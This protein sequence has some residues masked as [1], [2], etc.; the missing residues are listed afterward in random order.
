DYS[1]RFNEVYDLFPV[2]RER[3]KE[4]A[5]K[6]SGGQRQMVAMGRALMVDPEVLLLD[7]PAPFGPMIE[8][9]SPDLALILTL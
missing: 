7:F 4:K 6:L 8:A 1:H 5:G 3:R 2:M 9:I